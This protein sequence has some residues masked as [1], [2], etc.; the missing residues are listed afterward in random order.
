[1]HDLS[2]NGYAS[3]SAEPEINLKHLPLQISAVTDARSSLLKGL[4]LHPDL[5]TKESVATKSDLSDSGYAS[6]PAKPELNLKHLPL[7]IFAV[8]DARSCLL[9]GL[10]LRPDL[11]T[12]LRPCDASGDEADVSDQTE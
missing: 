11:Q 9:K 10:G 5:R 8:T 7:Q 6:G 4:G 1:M 3:G 12:T 2:D